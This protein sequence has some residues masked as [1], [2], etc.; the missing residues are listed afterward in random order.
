M[1][2]ETKAYLDQRFAAVDRRFDAVD[3]RFDAMDQRFEQ[4]MELIQ[5]LTTGRP[6][7]GSTPSNARSTVNPR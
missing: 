6:P 1:D 5:A 3:R 2:A 7:R 4:V